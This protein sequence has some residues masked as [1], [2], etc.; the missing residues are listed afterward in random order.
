MSRQVS[1]GSAGEH[2][3]DEQAGVARLRWRV[4]GR[5]GLNSSP[6]GATNP[7]VVHGSQPQP[8]MIMCTDLSSHDSTALFPS[9]YRAALDVSSCTHSSACCGLKACVPQIHL[10]KPNLGGWCLEVGPLEVMGS[11]GWTPQGEVS[12]PL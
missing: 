5:D 3:A 7:S 9:P 4:S 10:L 2:Q 12:A 1:R 11:G 8:F 6:L